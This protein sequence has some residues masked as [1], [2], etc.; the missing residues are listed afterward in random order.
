[1][2]RNPLSRKRR[3]TYTLS[4]EAI[5]IIEAERRQR[6]IA[7]ASSALEELLKERRRQKQMAVIRQSISNYYDSLSSEELGEQQ[8]WGEFSESQFRLE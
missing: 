2:P 1:M 6:K 3:K 7:S 8:L 5:A 4:S